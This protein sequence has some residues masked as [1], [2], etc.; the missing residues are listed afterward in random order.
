MLL[1]VLKHAEE[2]VFMLS[3]LL[4]L[5][6]QRPAIPSTLGRCAVLGSLEGSRL[7]SEM[8]CG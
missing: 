3:Q 2:H 5:R 6:T 1:A 7:E 8:S 4:Q